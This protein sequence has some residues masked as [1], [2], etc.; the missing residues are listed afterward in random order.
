VGARLAASA[1]ALLLEQGVKL[2]PEHVPGRYLVYGVFSSEPLTRAQIKAVLGDE[3]RGQA[4]V[5]V[6]VRELEITP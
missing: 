2:G 3:L 5:N 1:S 4:G 6:V